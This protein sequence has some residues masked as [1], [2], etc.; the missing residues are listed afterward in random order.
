MDSGLI[1]LTLG[2][3]IPFCSE[4]II[5]GIQISLTQHI[6]FNFS[7]DLPTSGYD[8]ERLTENAEAFGLR[9][10]FLF[11]TPPVFAPES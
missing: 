1:L 8:T 2:P 11:L 6:P 10:D 9:L 7:S 3:I 5:C 4:V